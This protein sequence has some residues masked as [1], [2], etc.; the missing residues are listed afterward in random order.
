MDLACK[1]Q[2]VGFRKV[3]VN[4]IEYYLIFLLI[5]EK[6]DSLPSAQIFVIMPVCFRQGFN[7]RNLIS[8]LKV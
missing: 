7:I 2:F 3:S 1:K 6:S 8:C 4:L 5:L